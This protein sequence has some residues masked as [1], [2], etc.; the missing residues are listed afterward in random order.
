[1]KSYNGG[2][3]GGGANL[4]SLGGV[5]LAAFLWG[6]VIGT[7][8]DGLNAYAQTMPNNPYGGGNQQMMMVQPQQQ[9]QQQ[10]PRQYP[11]YDAAR[12]QQQPAATTYG[13][14]GGGR[15]SSDAVL[16]ASRQQPAMGTT[17]TAPNLMMTRVPPAGSQQVPTSFVPPTTSNEIDSTSQTFLESHNDLRCRHGVPP[18]VWSPA[19][20]KLAENRA[21]TCSA[22]SP[23]EMQAQLQPYGE[24]VALGI[25]NTV[26]VV[27]TWYAEEPLYAQ[28]RT[29]RF[30]PDTGHFTAIVWKGTKQV[31]CAFQTCADPTVGAIAVCLYDPPGNIDTPE[32]FQENVLAPSKTASTCEDSSS[33]SS[34]PMM[35]MAPTP[36]STS[37]ATPTSTSTATAMMARQQPTAT[38]L[39]SDGTTVLINSTSVQ[40]VPDVRRVDWG[41]VAFVDVNWSQ[42]VNGQ[43]TKRYT[44]AE[45]ANGLLFIPS[46]DMQMDM[47]TLLRV[48]ETAERTRVGMGE[49]ATTVTDAAKQAVSSYQASRGT[50]VDNP[51]PNNPSSC[52]EIASYGF[53][54][55]PDMQGFCDVS[56]GRCSATNQQQQ[57]GGRALVRP[58]P[59][60]MLRRVRCSWGTMVI[61]VEGASPGEL[62]MLGRSRGLK[63]QMSQVQSYGVQ[64][65]EDRQSL[66]MS[67]CRNTALELT[68]TYVHFTVPCLT[69]ESGCRLLPWR[70]PRS[71]VARANS[72]GIVS[73]R[74]GGY[75]RGSCRSFVYQAVD[76]GTC[77][78]SEVLDTRS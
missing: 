9:Q 19:L 26:E 46:G 10:Q 43:S 25:A 14:G 20:A 53:C 71:Q 37:T 2:G 50:C 7:P 23:P 76:L 4:G 62:V 61:E 21:A 60:M 68:G 33:S 3:G 49:A 65:T 56:C 8:N 34:T 74:W 18:L 1:M 73:F 35:T 63:E 41:K 42:P 12:Q 6:V 51:P 16:A 27:Q 39:L 38:V 64:P 77:A 28:R 78:V 45:V 69:S 31:G 70:G 15:P 67:K 32:M 59:S 36:T 22:K 48:L 5:L 66:I 54:N 52:T 55:S 40:L 11:T 30:A 29:P 17:T 13:G 75:T 47:S 24:N 44:G 72:Q 58:T 57:Q